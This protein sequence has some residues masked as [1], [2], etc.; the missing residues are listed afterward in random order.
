MVE[1]IKQYIEILER[2]ISSGQKT[3]IISVSSGAKELSSELHRLDPR[4]FEPVAQ[5]EILRVRANLAHLVAVPSYPGGVSDNV[6]QQHLAQAKRVLDS[7]R[8]AGSGGVSRQFAFLSSKDLRPIVER[9]YAELRIK[10]FPSGAWK[11]VV[12]IAGSILEA[13]LFDRL[14]DAKWNSK[15]LANANVP[16]TKSGS[17][18]PMD[19]WKLANLIQVAV[20]IDLLPRNPADTIHQVLREYR[21]FVHPKAE[22]RAAHPCTEAEAMLAVGALDSVCNYLEKNCR[23]N[24]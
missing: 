22:I 21:N 8:G 24:P 10:L 18:I 16:K 17:Q 20:N 2:A 6:F 1:Y 19:D 5:A 12:I 3:E 14:S 9:D 4:D 15:A 13:I 23:V 7:Y 11:S